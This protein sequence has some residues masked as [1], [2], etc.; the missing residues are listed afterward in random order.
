[1]PGFASVRDLVLG[2]MR[3][4][5]PRAAGLDALLLA[6]LG[7]ES[8]ARTT[9][10][11][12][13]HFE[14]LVRYRNREFGH[15]AAGQRPREHYERFGEALLLGIHEVFS[16]VDPLCGRSPIHVEDV[17][18]LPTGEWLAQR[19]ELLGETARRQESL[20][21]PADADAAL[22]PR[23]GCLYLSG[24][25]GRLLSLHPLVF[26]LVDS[27]ETFFLNARRGRRSSEHLAYTSGRVIEREDLLAGRRE[28]VARLLATEVEAADLEAFAKAS[29]AEE[30][31]E[32]AQPARLERTAPSR[33]G[34]FELLT[35]LGRGGMGVVY[36]AYQPSLGRQVALKTLLRSGDASSET[37]FRREITALGRVE[38]PN[39][40]KV[41]MSGSDGE[42]WF[43]AMELIEGADLGSICHHLSSTGSDRIT[44]E[45][46]V[47][48]LGSACAEARAQEEPISD[49]TLAQATTRQP[50]PAHDGRSVSSR[51]SLSGSAI[52]R[53]VEIIREVSEA[54]EALHAG[55][56][57]H[58]DIKPGNVMLTPEGRQ[59]VLLDLDLAQLLDET[60]GRITR[61]RQFVGTLR[62]ASPEQ[63]LAVERLDA[64]SDVYSLGATL[65]ELLT[66]K[67]LFGA[68][69]ETPSP[70]LMHKIMHEEPSRP[71]AWNPEVPADLDAVVMKCIE[72]RPEHRYASAR[73][74]SLDLARWMRREPVLAQPLT[75]R[76]V[77]GKFVG[78]HRKGLTAASA[79]FL[80]LAAL[81]TFFVVN[82]NSARQTA[83]D[84]AALAQENA[85]RAQENAALADSRLTDW[86]RMADVR[87]LRDLIDEADNAL[88]PAWPDRVP[89][90]K[91]WLD[92]AGELIDRLPQHRTV[93]E[94]LRNK[95]DPSYT[96]ADRRKDR[97][98]HP[99]YAEY[100]E[101]AEK[102]RQARERLE[103]LKAQS[104]PSE[105]R[106][107]KAE[108][109]LEDANE[110][111]Q[112]LEA[113]VSVR[114][115]WRLESPDD[116]YQHEVFEELVAG[117]AKLGDPKR[118]LRADVSARR[119]Q[120]ATLG[121]RTIEGEHRAVWDQALA[122]IV[123]NPKYGGLRLKP[124]WGL[125]PLGPDPQS[126]FEEFAVADSGE[127]PA[128]DPEDRKLVLS[129]RMGIV[130]VLLPGGTF[131]MGAQAGSPSEKNYDPGASSDESPVHEV[132]LSSFFLAK[133]EL[134]RA[135]WL[136]VDRVDPSYYAFGTTRGG[137][138]VTPRNPV[139]YL[140]WEDATRVLHRFGL[141]LPTEAQWE[142]ACRAGTDTV[143]STGRTADTLKGFANIGDEGSK[144]FYPPGWNFE[145]GF[146]DGHAVHA[147]IGSFD[148]NG[149]GLHDMHGN[150]WE[151]CRDGHE[152]YTKPVRAG[153]DLR[154]LEAG[155]RVRVIRGGSFDV[156]ARLARSAIRNRVSPRS[157]SRTSGSAPRGSS[158]SDFTT[159]PLR[160]GARPW[161]AA[162]TAG[163][164]R[165]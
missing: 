159:S 66:L 144:S 120:A 52:H 22:L 14:R 20:V 135:Q 147:P 60:E 90:M 36:R 100:L 7:Q 44:E 40:V 68:T 155:A 127:V 101:S 77:M 70:E 134:T 79:G 156:P 108:E 129:D 55:K 93:L 140:S 165:Q 9:V 43:Y 103:T 99:R 149:F 126:T 122:R 150:A 10:R 15:G 75:F 95:A 63:V 163:G 160:I 128:R 51:T 92:R 143:F 115:T 18:R 13:E 11:L 41:H 86:R 105:A 38:H 49:G 118:G 116:Q 152:P 98:S 139:A 27:G 102:L 164:M 119:E 6:D 54:A 71:S 25:D 84:N 53:A 83:E 47:E 117:V 4:D 162:S 80:G 8:G 121:M 81:L 88:W 114:R 45:A 161:D 30:P 12:T 26:H 96:E 3:D 158:R 62:Y 87:L 31:R 132:S 113:V 24:T 42:H 85:A 50:A 124:Q 34:D 130:L 107:E 29:E 89:V 137:R 73:E 32:P 23:P 154:G 74:L 94:T 109:A 76:Y 131:S 133:Y 48:A 58:R 153:D 35:R 104:R 37:R 21:F 138:L 17:R 1:V 112:S 72:K 136:C 145:P 39:L 61:T 64:R 111:L 16:R 141:V 28:L 148:A 46:W 2:R 106:V 19:Y 110:K 56:V 33:L 57:V 69:D 125:L 142:Y 59:A 151:W 157:A 97:E 82:L 67:P 123:A 5:M 65:W 78:R 146:E 91:R